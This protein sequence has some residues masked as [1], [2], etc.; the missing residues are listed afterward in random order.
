[1]NSIRH[2]LGRFALVPEYIIADVSPPAQKMW[3]ILWIYSGNGTHDAWPSHARLAADMG[4]SRRTVQRIIDDLHDAGA[5]SVQHRQGTSSLYT[6]HWSRRHPQ[7]TSDATPY[8][9]SDAPPTT[10]V[11]HKERLSEIDKHRGAQSDSRVHL[12]TAGDNPLTREEIRRIREQHAD[13][14][15]QVR[16]QSPDQ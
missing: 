3:C 6:L 7:D 8:D 12:R 5:L 1:M 16:I 9:T 10:L 14:E 15:R 13:L 2:D 4:C 11:T